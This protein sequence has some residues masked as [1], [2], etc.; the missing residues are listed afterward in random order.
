[1]PRTSASLKLTKDY[2]KGIAA[3]VRCGDGRVV[4][5]AQIVRLAAQG[6]GATQ[7]R[8]L[9][10]VSKSAVHKIIK[11]FRHN[12]LAALQ[13]KPKS[14]RPSKATE[15]FVTCLKD[16]VTRSPRDLEYV[17]SSWTLARLCEHVGRRCKT[18]ISVPQLSRIM[19]KHGIVY[20]RPRHVMAHL[21][22]QTEYDEKKELLAFL[23]KKPPPPK[24]PSSSSSLMSVRFISTR[25]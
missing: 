2:E 23:K 10:A 7:I 22:N 1:M 3:A 6:I 15:A 16:A 21:R 24:H 13:D 17:F 14:G 25:P 8:K 20:R 11:A 12:G 9:L 19:R 5:R 4:R 18:S